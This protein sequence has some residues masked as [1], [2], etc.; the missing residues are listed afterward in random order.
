MVSVGLAEQIKFIG[1]YYA[2]VRIG[3]LFGSG[4]EVQVD[5]HY[6]NLPLLGTK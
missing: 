1:K 4:H 3:R 6:G 5:W 2:A